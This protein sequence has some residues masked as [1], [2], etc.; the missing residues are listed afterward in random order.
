MTP[1]D[2]VIWALAICIAW[3]ILSSCIPIENWISS[4]IASVA[5]RRDD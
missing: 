4:L 5:K 3:C 1:I 2:I